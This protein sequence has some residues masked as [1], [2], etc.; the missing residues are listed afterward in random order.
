[1]EPGPHRGIVAALVPQRRLHAP[2]EES[3]RRPARIGRNE[4]AIALKG[5]AV[6]IAAQDDPFGELA[7]DRI[8]DRRFRLGSIGRLVLA[9]Q[10][11][12]VFQ[13]LGVGLRGR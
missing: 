7:R 8:S 13:R 1:M 3:L 11:D 4:C 12:D 9:H 5:R 10:L 2:A 6:L